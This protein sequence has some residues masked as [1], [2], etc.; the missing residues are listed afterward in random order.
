VKRKGSRKLKQKLTVIGWRSVRAMPMMNW[1]GN[2]WHSET[3]KQKPSWMENAMPTARG[4]LKRNCSESG[5]RKARDL[6][7]RMLTETETHLA[8]AKLNCWTTGFGWQKVK[9]KPKVIGSHWHYC[10]ETKRHSGT[11][12]GKKL[13]CN[14]R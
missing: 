3:G 9:G 11:G 14:K 1:T 5:K 13:R 4:K 6:R 12:S 10:S 8:R 2:G 7:T